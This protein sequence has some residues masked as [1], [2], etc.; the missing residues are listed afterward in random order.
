MTMAKKCG[1]IR[2]FFGLCPRRRR[3][4]DVNATSTREFSKGDEVS[5]S[6]V[7]HFNRHGTVVKIGKGLVHVYVNLIDRVVKFRPHHL[8]VI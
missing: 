4:G 6:A 1:P 3:L 5:I 8:R 2:R 7:Q